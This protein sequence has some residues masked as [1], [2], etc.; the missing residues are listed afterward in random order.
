MQRIPV[1]SLA[2][3]SLQ[4]PDIREQI[5]P[6]LLPVHPRSEPEHYVHFRAGKIVFVA[7]FA[8]KDVQ[9]RRKM[10]KPSSRTESEECP[11]H[12]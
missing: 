7:T 4:R 2:F 11:L 3:R 9:T 12:G 5:L 8:H 6:T 1:Q 10:T